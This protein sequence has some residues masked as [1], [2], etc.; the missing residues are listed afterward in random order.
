[1]SSQHFATFTI[2]TEEDELEEEEHQTP[3]EALNLVCKKGFAFELI[4]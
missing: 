1:M 2:N 3:S 4:K